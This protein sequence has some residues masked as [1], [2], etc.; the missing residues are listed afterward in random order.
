MF[1]KYE[2]YCRAVLRIVTALLYMQHGAQKL[3]QYPP[4]GHNQGS[5]ELLSL[6][7]V[8]GILEFFGGMCILLGFFTRTVAF[9]LSGQMAVAYFMF[10]ASKS[11]F[12]VVNGGELAIMF[13]FVYFY[14][15]FAG[16]GAWSVDALIKSK[17]N[18]TQT[19]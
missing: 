8:A 1:Y 14:L 18:H 5:L 17:L 4:G 2:T 10:Y 3:F 9:V 16:P 19:N 7:G 12:P 11:I 15:F 6:V 13:C